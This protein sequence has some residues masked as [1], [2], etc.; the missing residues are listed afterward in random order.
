ME[1]MSGIGPYSIE[2][3]SQSRH[4][5]Q[6]HHLIPGVSVGSGPGRIEMG[7]YAGPHDM[8]VQQCTTEG[9]HAHGDE[10]AALAVLQ[11]QR[12]HWQAEAER[13]NRIVHAQRDRIRDLEGSPNRL[14]LRKV[15]TYL[16]TIGKTEANTLE[17]QLQEMLK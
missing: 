11:H 1:R 10:A 9:L 16:Q 14:L 13:L 15:V 7:S 12:L 2:R 17:R 3:V 4:S 5:H 8:P 6:N